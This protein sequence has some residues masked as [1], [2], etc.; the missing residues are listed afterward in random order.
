MEKISASIVISESI[1]WKAIYD[2]L[3][4]RVFHF[5][6]YK[7]G[8][9]L[10]AEELTAITFEKAWGSRENY[11]KDVGAFQFWLLGIA[12]K[13]AADH[14]RRRRH[15]VPLD[16]VDLPSHQNVEKEFESQMDFER[17][18]SMLDTLPDRERLLISLK[19]G[20]E[21][22]NREI[23]KQTG[24]SESNVGTILFRVVAKLREE[25]EK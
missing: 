2:H 18:S 24:L 13:V 14:F 21:L 12:Q 17:L 16:T 6:C 25:W 3:L 19:Y 9:K 20:A 8:D 15:E 7:T 23:A 22:N 1:N 5:F 11:R 10:V 4:P